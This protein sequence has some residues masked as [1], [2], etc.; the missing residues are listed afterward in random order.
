MEQKMVEKI[1]TMLPLLNEKQKRLYLASEAIAM[2][3]GGIAE[4]SRASG[5]SRSVISAGI[6]DITAGDSEGLSADAPIRRKGAG[7]KPITGTQPGIKEALNDLV[8]DATYGNPENPLCWTTKS[9]R[10]LASELQ[11][12]GFKIGYRKV[13]YLLKEMGYSLQMNQKMNQ[14]GEEHPDRDEQFQHINQEVKAFGSAGLPVISID[15]KKKELVGRFKNS[16]SEYAP[17]GRAIEVLD[18]DFPLPEL[19][20]AAPYGIYD[21]AANEGFVSVGISSDTAQFAVA[22]IRSWWYS[23]GIERYPAA[24]KLLI[25]A[26]GGGSNGSR[27]RL[28]KTEL[29]ALANDTGLEISVCHFPPGTSK[30]NKIEHR[31]FSQISKNWRGRPLETL[32]IIV[33][34]IASTSTTS[35]LT[36]QCQLDQ[37]HYPKG[38]KITDLELASVNTVGDEF[39]PNWNYTIIPL[40]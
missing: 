9:L 26:D 28:W 6:K 4:V 24:N 38:I 5:I 10:N 18:H 27:N 12:K 14:V 35:G 19:G 37:N 30:W 36:I 13:G 34:L 32:Q 23:M 20:K 11:E 31:M 3:R 8:C 33:N 15:C 22:S 1:K 39:H 21:I 7:R 29:Q 16:G 17:K 2:G 40:K 25:T